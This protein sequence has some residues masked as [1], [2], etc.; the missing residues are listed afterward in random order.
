[1]L[2]CVIKNRYAL[3]ILSCKASNESVNNG[4]V[5][6]WKCKHPILWTPPNKKIIKNKNNK[7]IKSK[8]KKI[9]SLDSFW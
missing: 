7:I 2:S 9:C 8:I 5:K 4:S 1:M 3:L 6:Q